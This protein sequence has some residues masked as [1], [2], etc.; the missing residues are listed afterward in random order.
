MGSTLTTFAALLKERYL[1]PGIVEKLVYPENTLF[2]LLEKSGDTG[3]V[4]DTMPVPVLYGNPQGTGGTF[5]T[6][7]TNATNLTADAWAIQM[8]D[9]FGVVLIGDKVL[10]ASRNN[11]GAF[12][13]NKR[14]E[15]DGLW[16]TAADALSTYLWGNGGYAL[17][18][19]TF[20]SDTCTMVNPEQICNIELNMEVCFGANDG[21]TSTD[22]LRTG[23]ST[24]DA[25]DR[26]NGT[27]DITASDITG[28]TDNDYVFRESDFF[29]TTG[30]VIIRGVQCFVTDTDSP[31]TLWG[32]ANTTRAKDLQR[33]SG[34][35]VKASRLNGLNMEDRIK[36]L[37]ALMTGAYKSKSPTALFVHPEDFM[38]LETVLSARGVRPLEDKST[39]F[40]YM[41]IDIVTAAGTIPIYTDRHCPKGTAFALRMENWK[42]HSM[43]EILHP[44]TGDG[45][46]ILRKYNATD[47]EYR[48]LSYPGA[49]CNA[50]KNSGRVALY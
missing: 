40:G 29:G 7:Q 22:T 17:G 2:G 32:V 23:A 43:G 37:L 3:M 44:M 16:E 13:D 24:V 33:W 15:I 42:L 45:N 5:T 26:A 36:L 27:F 25:V 46:E 9:Y 30:N 10:K 28:E 12:L 47:Y 6:A 8:G 14:I 1:D 34:C 39:K 50:P 18:R 49:S 21:A 19:V 20:S 38:T 41:K 11:Q 4:G 35:R 31:P 48:L